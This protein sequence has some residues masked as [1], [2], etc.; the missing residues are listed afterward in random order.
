MNQKLQ[1][2]D[3]TIVTQQQSLFKGEQ[4]IEISSTAYKLLTFFLDHPNKTLSRTQLTEHVWPKRVV[5]ETS[6]DKLIQRLRQL[7][8]DT[9]QHKKVIRT[10]HGVGFVFLPEVKIDHVTVNA[11]AKKPWALMSLPL[12][13]IVVMALYYWYQ[14]ENQSSQKPTPSAETAT[15]HQVVALIPDM[16][17]MAN[18]DQSWM[19]RGGLYYLKEQF[20]QSMNLEIKNISLKKLGADDP[21]RFAIEL[22]NK[23]TV[24]A[25]VIVEVK[26][27]D[28]QFQASVTI[29]NAD[30]ILAAKTLS[31]PSI[32]SLYDEI[33]A[34]VKELLSIQK[35]PLITNTESTMSQDSYAVENYIRGMSAQASGYSSEA[36]KYFELATKEDPKFWLAWY[37][38]SLAYRKQG[39]YKK[40]LAIIS[41]FENVPLTDTNDLMI[42]NAKAV[43]LYF[44][45]EYATG[46]DV[47]NAGIE[48]AKKSQNYKELSTFLTNKAL[49][50]KAMGDLNLALASTEEAIAIAQ[51][52]NG[53]H[54]GK[55][56]S[57]YNTLAGIEMNMN[58]L[59]AAQSHA[60]LAADYFNKAGDKR[61]EA[62]AKSRLSSIHYMLGDWNTGEN[63]IK[64]VLSIQQAL[65]D[66]LGQTTSY[67]RL[68][69]YDFLR[70][71]FTAAEANL[72]KLSD[73]MSD[74]SNKYQNDSFLITKIKV[75]LKSGDYELAENLLAEL[76]ENITDNNRLYTYYLLSLDLYELKND[77]SSWLAVAK[78][79][80]ENQDFG[81]QPYTYLIKAKAAI[82]QQNNSLA[83]DA[84]EQAKQIAFEQRATLAIA[85]VMNPYIIFLLET[86]AEKAYLNLL[87]LEKYSVPV[88][89]YL[90]TKAQ[91]LSSK[92]EF[93]KASSLLEELKT[94]A[95]DHWTVDDQLLMEKYRQ[96]I[97]NDDA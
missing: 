61:Y 69:D 58:D 9:E 51:S 55:L 21:E 70:G 62:T 25:S 95:A 87:E 26:E 29:R 57:S 2:L 64:E 75:K 97:I 82:K 83:Q 19:L 45:G 84:F 4:R 65:D 33:A 53:N 81:V 27:V 67:M 94:K 63:L 78:E 91:V 39:E 66:T 86:N 38:L 5:T 54:D 90:K 49:F 13:I 1:F 24:D 11:K 50:A 48:T 22:S 56:G 14:D 92:G 44:L 15:S 40:A 3:F 36:I 37:E 68:C 28:D 17:S 76:K 10:I 71:D 43:N 80:T 79:F 7:L 35:F 73:L 89:P 31:S 18:Q 32:K 52:L 12:L 59:E 23:K 88:Y 60:K 41:V 85:D 77:P 74:V 6:L 16:A 20:N 46:I 72:D 47:L 8:G 93:F 34:W 96:A 30:G 42:Q